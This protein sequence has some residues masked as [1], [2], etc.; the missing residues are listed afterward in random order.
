MAHKLLHTP[1]MTSSMLTS[2]EQVSSFSIASLLR[3]CD[4]DSKQSPRMGHPHKCCSVKKTGRKSGSFRQTDI[5][6]AF[7]G[8]SAA[9]KDFS[10]PDLTEGT[11]SFKD[12]IQS[13]DDRCNKL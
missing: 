11:Y 9:G 7:S 12:G 1:S 10:E 5:Q 6:S 13:S 8:S 4:E 3:C 2:N